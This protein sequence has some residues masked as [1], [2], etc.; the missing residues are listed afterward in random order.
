MYIF[1]L[2]NTLCDS[3]HRSHLAREK[4]WD[5][6]HAAAHL[7]EPTAIMDI[8]QALVLGQEA[9]AIL[10]GRNEKYRELTEQWF[11]KH[12]LPLVD[13]FM[14]ANDD[15]RPDFEFKLDAI[16]RYIVFPSMHKKW[17]RI[18]EDRDA[19]VKALR[20]EGYTVLQVRESLY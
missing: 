16:R 7:D 1:D 6:F 12:D 14:R 5:E 2:D 13:L 11:I 9:C 4:R 19:V 3:E 15:F 20:A 17:V 18:F 10:T 8:Y